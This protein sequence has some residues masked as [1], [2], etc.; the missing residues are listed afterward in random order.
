MPKPAEKNK[1]RKQPAPEKVQGDGKSVEDSYAAEPA[2]TYGPA[3]KSKEKGK[4]EPAAAKAAKRPAVRKPQDELYTPEEQRVLY[5][6]GRRIAELR[7]RRG[8]TQVQLAEKAGINRTYLGL[9]ELGKRNTHLLNLW[10]LCR[11]LKA[12]LSELLKTEG[13]S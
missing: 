12:S 3:S 7:V 11:A 10:K 4:A 2:A 8:L 9:I 6:V 5:K 13:L 1:A